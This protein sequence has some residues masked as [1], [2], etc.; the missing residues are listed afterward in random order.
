[1]KLFEINE[2]LSNRN[3]INE[4]DTGKWFQTELM[5]LTLE[6][7]LISNRNEINE[8]DFSVFQHLKSMKLYRPISKEWRGV[9]GQNLGDI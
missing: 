6:I 8:I 9:R 7:S 4:I 5:A 1:M 2:I 3:E